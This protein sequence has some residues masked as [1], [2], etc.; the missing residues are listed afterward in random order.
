MYQQYEM[1]KKLMMTVEKKNHA[2]TELKPIC[3]CTHTFFFSSFI[4]LIV[5]VCFWF[6]FV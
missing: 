4:C 3:V 6:G 5:R 2:E 1:D